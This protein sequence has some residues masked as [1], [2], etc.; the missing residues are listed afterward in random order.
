MSKST[1]DER[2][3]V[4]EAVSSKLSPKPNTKEYLRQHR[5]SKPYAF[6][7]IGYMEQL[8]RYHNSVSSQLRIEIADLTKAEKEK[9]L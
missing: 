9:Q 8:I 5:V 3:H 1:E 4:E 2:Q 7:D 6:P